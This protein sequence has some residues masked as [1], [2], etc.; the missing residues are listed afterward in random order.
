MEPNPYEA[1]NEQGYSLPVP[2]ARKKFSVLRVLAISAA[3]IS[4]LIGGGVIASIVIYFLRG[5]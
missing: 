4:V 3:L 2:V 5:G 1:P